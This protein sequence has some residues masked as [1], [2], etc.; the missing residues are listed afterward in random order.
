MI[1]DL[2]DFVFNLRLF[3]ED[4]FPDASITSLDEAG[5]LHPGSK[6]KMR[7]QLAVEL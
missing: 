5:R 6:C 7:S 2:L 3:D 1:G 4:A